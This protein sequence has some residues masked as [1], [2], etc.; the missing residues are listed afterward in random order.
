[1]TGFKAL[2]LGIQHTS[3]HGWSMVRIPRRLNCGDDRGDATPTRLGPCKAMDVVALWSKKMM[4]PPPGG[5]GRQFWGEN[6]PELREF[7]PNGRWKFIKIIKK[8]HQQPLERI[9]LVLKRW[10]PGITALGNAKPDTNWS[11]NPGHRYGFTY[12]EAPQKDQDN[13]K[14]TINALRKRIRIMKNHEK[15]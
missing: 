11:R 6:S 5:I 10:P 8:S 3:S 1:M 7:G 12:V 15:A 2:W 9:F 13:A 14:H 4:N